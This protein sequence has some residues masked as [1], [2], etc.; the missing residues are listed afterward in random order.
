MRAFYG[1]II[2][3]ACLPL[4][5][6]SVSAAGGE[7]LTITI[8]NNSTDNVLLTAYDRNA[9][10]AQLVLSGQPLYGFASIVIS[11]S[12]NAAGLGHLSW[13]ART[14]D[15]DMATCGNGNAAGLHDGDT[16]NVHADSHCGA[17]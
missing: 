12:A 14:L 3:I 8:S 5:V 17:R 1:L 13:T 4:S 7:G 9:K 2:A 6:A 11:I 15:P 16:L 10:P